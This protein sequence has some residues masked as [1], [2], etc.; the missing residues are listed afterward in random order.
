MTAQQLEQVN[1]GLPRGRHPHSPQTPRQHQSLRLR[2]RRATTTSPTPIHRSMG[3]DV[4]KMTLTECPSS[5]TSATLRRHPRWTP[6]EK[7]SERQRAKRH[8]ENA[9][10]LQFISHAGGSCRHARTLLDPHAKGRETMRE[11]SMFIG[12]KTATYSS[13]TQLYY[14]PWT[15]IVLS[16][17]S[18]S[19]SH[20]QNASSRPLDSHGKRHE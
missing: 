18:C 16:T 7:A 1:D 19:V 4:C 15:P 9:H 14:L 10:P 12:E 11:G 6:M 17:T 8:S 3:D 13:G 20:V 5:P 2:G